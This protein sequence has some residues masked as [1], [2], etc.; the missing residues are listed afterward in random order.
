MADANA[1]FQEEVNQIVSHL[2]NGISKILNKNLVGI[3]LFGSLTYGDFNIESS[4]IDFMAILNNPASKDEVEALKKLHKEVEGKY[5]K[6]A[7][8]LESSY[9]PH[10]MLLSITP[11]GAR[12]YHGEGIF[13]E[14]APYGNEWI[15]NLYLLY[16]Y[17]I[18]IVGPEFSS[19]VSPIKIE[20]VQAACIKDLFKEWEP[21]LREPEWLDD[22]H[23]QS[24]LVMN[25]C[26]ILNTVT[27]AT[28]L[29]KIKSADWVKRAYPEWKELIDTAEK[30]HYG[31]EMKQKEQALK[32]L[33]F[34]ILEVDKIT[35]KEQ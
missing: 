27:N 26:R 10:Q 6:W 19:L 13:Y 9:T 5:P 35:H 2:S 20:D 7:K 15:I 25:L 31:Q 11:P 21:K 33:E 30:W 23:Y 1:N 8:R 29:S 32:F 24:Y 16:K 14:Q 4:D 18:A 12:P 34:V 17:G 22:P 3:Y 28:T